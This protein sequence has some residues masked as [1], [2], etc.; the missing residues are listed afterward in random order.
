MTTQR[1]PKD[2]GL[3]NKLF[4]SEPL[5]LEPGEMFSMEGMLASALDPNLTKLGDVTGMPIEQ[6]KV[7]RREFSAIARQAGLFPGVAKAIHNAWT[8]ARLAPPMDE[9]EED[10]Q[11]REANTE[12]RRALREKW[13]AEDA[14]DLL[15]RAQKFVGQ[16]P[17]LAE[18][19]ST[20]GIGSRKE[21]VLALTE[22]VRHVNF[23]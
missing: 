19:L 18:I 16:H 22:H 15:A 8:S 5:K 9:A 13:G 11:L 2:D 10:N 1:T 6:Q 3:S 14:E 17:R 7:E 12:T 20:G 23:R 4:D 21:I